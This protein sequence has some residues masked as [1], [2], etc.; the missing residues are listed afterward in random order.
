MKAIFYSILILASVSCSTKVLNG[1]NKFM[2]K[3]DIYPLAL[4]GNIKPVLDN[5]QNVADSRL[6][7]E[8]VALKR[9]YINRFVNLEAEPHNVPGFA[10]DVLKIHE[11]YWKKVLRNDLSV[12][13]GYHFWFEN[14]SALASKHGKNFGPFGDHEAE[15]LVEFISLELKKLGYY[16]QLGRTKPHMDLLLWHK[17]EIKNYPIN[18]G[19]TS[20]TVPVVIMDDFITFGWLGFATFNDHYTG[21][22]ADKNRLYCVAP[23]YDLESEKFQ[24]SYLAH[25]GRHFSD[26]NRFPKLESVDLEYRAKLTEIVLAKSISKDLLKKFIKEA[27]SSQISPHASASYHLI[28]ELS[29]NLNTTLSLENTEKWDENAIRDQAKTLLADH[30]KKLEAL[31]AGSTKGT[32]FNH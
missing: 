24:I 4:Q 7:S 17:Q 22:W 11:L 2:E 21:G 20:I 15:R 5:F 9:L 25:E 1:K 19:D 14:L 26:Y 31:G 27:D 6:S 23:A 12:E 8:Q 32:Y 3:S 13:E 10:G 16:S 28:Q 30:S 29:K 18:L